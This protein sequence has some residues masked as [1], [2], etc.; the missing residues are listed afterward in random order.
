LRYRQKNDVTQESCSDCDD[1]NMCPICWSALPSNPKVL[2]CGHKFCRKCIRELKSYQA[3]REAC[4]PMCRGP[5]K[6]ASAKHL[7]REAKLHE[8][9]GNDLS[10]LQQVEVRITSVTHLMME[11]QREYKKA[12]TKL[13]ECLQVLND[14]HA[15][16]SRQNNGTSR[17]AMN[18]ATRRNS[19]HRHK[20]VRVLCKMTEIV[21]MA[22]FEDGDER[23]IELLRT[24]LKTSDAP[25]PHL[26]LKLA[27][28]LHRQ[29]DDSLLEDVKKEYGIILEIARLHSGM[30][31]RHAKKLR[32]QAHYGLARCYHQLGNYKRAAREY[33][34]C[35]RFNALQ[36]YGLAAECHFCIG[37]YLPAMDYCNMKLREE[38][39][40]PAIETLLLM[41]RICRSYFLSIRSYRRID[42]LDYQSRC[43]TY[44]RCVQH[45]QLL[46]RNDHQQH[47][48]SRHMELLYYLLYPIHK[49]K[50][51]KSTYCVTASSSRSMDQTDDADK[52]VD[53]D[54]EDDSS[55]ADDED[56]ETEECDS[57]TSVEL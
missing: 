37:N 1:D 51:M 32:G 42:A 18:S 3:E 16:K 20:Q 53:D 56:L 50:Q 26:N 11:S 23:C 6:R 15:S 35:E 19:K 28:L 46:A 36:D 49:K 24:A 31:S 5:L 14:D 48:C 38:S 52:D 27:K 41:A 10:R 4:C 44:R 2:P 22:R 54:E 43:E 57:E 17:I 47:E 29:L 21:P 39:T 12:V 30:A 7:W 45:A 8:K 9:A 25:M 40:R 34:S 55:C 13:K 33:N